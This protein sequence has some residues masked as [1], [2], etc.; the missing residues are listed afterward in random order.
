MLK[1][2]STLNNA[3]MARTSI[4]RNNTDVLLSYAHIL[5][6]SSWHL[7]RYCADHLHQHRHPE[8]HFEEMNPLSQRYHLLEHRQAHY[9]RQTHQLQTLE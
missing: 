6:A 2:V 9:N 4:T 8:R 3:P 5:A 7:Q 1:Y